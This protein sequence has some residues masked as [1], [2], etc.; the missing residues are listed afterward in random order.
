MNFDF[1]GL[2]C[3]Y[4]MHYRFIILNYLNE[5]RYGRLVLLILDIKAINCMVSISDLLTLM[6]LTFVIAKGQK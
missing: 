2:Y 4:E 6:L 3:I 1:D 5:I